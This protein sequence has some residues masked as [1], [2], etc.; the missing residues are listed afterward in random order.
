MLRLPDFTRARVLVVGDLM[1]DRYWSGAT[2]RISPEAPVP[3]VHVAGTEDRPGGAGNVALNLAAL[4]AHATVLGLT[5][6]DEA[7]AVLRARL[8]AAGVACAFE[9]V[10]GRATITKLRVLSRHQQLI[11]LDFED[12]FPGFEPARLAA[13][14]ARHLDEADVVV[15]S[16]YA[17]GCLAAVEPLIAAARAAGKPVLVDPKGQDF[18]RYRGATL[19]TPNEAEFAAVAGRWDDDAGLVARARALA[20]D[21]GFAQV[22]V[23]RSERGM[24]LVEAGGRAQHIASKAREVFD[25]TGAG[26]TVVATLAAALAAGSPLVDAVHLANTAA[27]VVVGKLGTATVSVAE[28]HAALTPA[29][30]AQA[31]VVG[32]PALLAEVAAARARGE[33][34]VMTNGCFDLLHAGHVAYLGEAAALGDRL[35]VAVN[36]DA[37]VGRLKGPA[38]PINPLGARMAVLAGLRAVDWVVP[39]AEDTPRELIARVL[40]DVLVKGGD[41]RPEDIVGGAEVLA[42]GGEVIVLGFVDGHSTTATVA[43]IRGRAD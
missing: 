24:T 9:V 32:V 15:C 11:R 22:L 37:S 17:K 2:R 39:F 35:I 5:G 28:L 18:R 31:G 6:D 14:F 36:D 20:A 21:C 8:E 7:A 34:V 12:G 38:R 26:D 13:T 4:G 33:R 1:L 30:P 25:V 42:A 27:G 43:R 41:Y 23:T 29:R 3:V 10:P 16:D 19:I 40:P